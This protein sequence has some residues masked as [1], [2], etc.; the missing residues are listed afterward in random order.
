TKEGAKVKK[1]A[2][3]CQW[4]PY[5]AVILAV[6]AGTATFEAIEEGA[7]YKEEYDDQTGHKQKVIIDSRDKKQNPTIIITN[8]KGEKFTYNIPVKARLMIEEGDQVAAGQIL[9]KIPRMLSKS[10]DITG[11]LPR[12]TELFEAR[13][14]SNT[15]VVSEINGVVA[16]GGIKRG[17]REIFVEAKDGTKKRYLVPLSKHILVQDN[18][19]VKAGYLLSD[20]AI[21][22]GHILAIKGPTAVQQYLI[23]ELQAV[24]RLQ[25][26]KINDK[27]IE[28][29]VR[30]MMSKVEII[31]SGD[32]V[33]A[34]GQSV[35][36]FVFTDENDRA[37]DKK[38]VTNAGGSQLFKVGDLVSVRKLQ[39]ENDELRQQ[40]L[41]LV[42]VRDAM[43]AIGRP[44]LQGI[45]QASLATE[46]FISAAS[47]QET[48]KV[49]SDA[50]IRG[51]SDTLKGLKENV[52]VGHLIP[53]GTGLQK[54][55]NLLVQAKKEMQNH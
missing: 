2:T 53:A 44:K 11:G 55:G 23:R 8:K 16:Y 31:D 45:T 42:Q 19:Y 38:V 17:N 34:T 6:S 46:S 14:P 47:F 27:H 28:I 37:L 51:K 41:K 30:Q 29:I 36:R 3:L 25:G 35:N 49:L 5:N 52:I 54:Y 50:A 13:N 21:A 33:F 40:G 18:D 39:D 4:D 43:P 48:T 26:V 1:G 7:T 20:G 10:R 24:Y 9:V 22:P 12:V 32:T 15:A